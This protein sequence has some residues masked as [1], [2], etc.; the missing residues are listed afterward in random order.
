[1]HT[2]VRNTNRF[3]SETKRLSSITHDKFLNFLYTSFV[4]RGWWSSTEMSVIAVRSPSLK[5]TVSV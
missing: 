4:D 5:F 3:S 1:M 2:T